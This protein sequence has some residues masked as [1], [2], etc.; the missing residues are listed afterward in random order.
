VEKKDGEKGSLGSVEIYG[1]G[2]K[3][4]DITATT[5]LLWALVYHWYA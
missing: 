5:H 4:E 3:E 1:I 2:T